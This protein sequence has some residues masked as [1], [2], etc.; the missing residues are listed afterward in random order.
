M[1]REPSDARAALMAVYLSQR[2]SFLN[3]SNV[4]TVT[5][6]V[7]P[8][9][10]PLHRRKY[11]KDLTTT[12]MFTK[13]RNKSL[14]HRRRSD[15]DEHMTRAGGAGLGIGLGCTGRTIYGVGVASGVSRKQKRRSD[16]RPGFPASLPSRKTSQEGLTPAQFAVIKMG[17]E[18]AR[19]EGEIRRVQGKRDARKK[20]NHHVMGH[21]KQTGDDMSLGGVGPAG[22]E[23]V[24]TDE[25]A[26][27]DRYFD[28]YIN[29]EAW[30]GN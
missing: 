9:E 14:P 11:A 26:H 28:M 4:S 23:T 24:G 20:E 27:A 8:A 3:P 21:M 5:N 18:I 30:V 19:Q 2:L 25:M 7:E 16:G 29:A 10:R 13:N 1:P 6:K 15:A 17:E 22:G 12:N